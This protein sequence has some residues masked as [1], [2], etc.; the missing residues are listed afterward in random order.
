MRFLRTN[1]PHG[2]AVPSD[3]DIQLTSRAAEMM[4][5]FE[6]SLLEHLIFAENRYACIMKSHY[7]L[8]NGSSGN[9]SKQ[10]SFLVDLDTF[11][12]IADEDCI[13]PDPFERANPKQ[14]QKT[15]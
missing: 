4:E 12:N 10:K 5:V 11:L 2:I 15:E 13:I 7:R 1:H 14:E 9:F 3:A 8:H 6:I